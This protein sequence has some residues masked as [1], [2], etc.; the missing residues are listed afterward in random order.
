M[1]VNMFLYK[2]ANISYK[3]GPILY[4]ILR[5]VFIGPEKVLFEGEG[6]KT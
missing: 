3:A 4:T 5:E 2:S 1:S 6:D